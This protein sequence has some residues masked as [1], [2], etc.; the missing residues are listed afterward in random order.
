M[1][2]PQNV[3]F[4][5]TANKDDST[6]TIT[7]KVYDR[8]TPIEINSKAEYVDAPATECVTISFDY[9]QE[10]FRQAV[11]DH[12]ISI[13]ALDNLE[14]LDLF[15]T[16][17]LKVTFGN[18]IMKQIRDFVPVYVACG[19]TEYEAL[20]FMVARKIFRKFESLNLPFLQTEITELSTLLDRLFG[21][22][23]FVEC[24]AYLNDIK[25]MY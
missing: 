21:K 25:K 14:K 15:V 1:L 9:L 20:D 22:N 3:W 10:L 4:I 13:K 24:Q 7:D 5:G 2:L 16:K 12:A 11:V 18:R 23:V 19:G 6:F 8:A 17:N